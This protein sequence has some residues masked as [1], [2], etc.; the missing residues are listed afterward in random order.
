MSALVFPPL[1]L[2]ASISLVDMGGTET[3]GCVTTVSWHRV[4]SGVIVVVLQGER[5][6]GSLCCPRAGSQAWAAV[7]QNI[8]LRN[9]AK[10]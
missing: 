6:T 9:P 2:S 5:A 10:L 1:L 8:P 4:W 7:S 3:Q